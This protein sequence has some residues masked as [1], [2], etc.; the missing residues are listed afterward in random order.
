VR[1]NARNQEAAGKAKSD[2]ERSKELTL[3]QMISSEKA[4]TED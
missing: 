1:E 3:K 4:S 2:S